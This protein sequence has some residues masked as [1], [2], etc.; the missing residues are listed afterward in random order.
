M[1]M[2]LKVA[3]VERIRLSGRCGDENDF[4][5]L[6]SFG[7]SV[8]NLDFKGVFEGFSRFGS[9]ADNVKFLPW[10]IAILKQ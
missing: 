8:K 1:N 2:G 9:Y 6:K 3:C 5:T 7:D 4:E 10:S